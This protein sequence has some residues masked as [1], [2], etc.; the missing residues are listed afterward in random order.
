MSTRLRLLIAL[1]VVLALGL[2]LLAQLPAR[3]AVSWFRDT[4]PE[5]RAQGLSGTV[6]TGRAQRVDWRGY[7]LGALAWQIRPWSVLRGRLLAELTLQGPELTA[8][9]VLTSS[10]DGT[11][12]GAQKM[13]VSAPAAWLQQV[14]ATPFLQLSGTLDGQFDS[15]LFVDGWL[16]ALEGRSTWNDAQLRGRIRAPLGGLVVEWTTLE[17]RISGR[18]RDTGGPLQALG[19][20]VVENR[21]YHL[22]VTLAA[23]E[24]NIPLR[25][26]LEVF[27]R[28]NSDGAVMLR[29]EGPMI[30]LR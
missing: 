1:V 20:V 18:I 21:G 30:P 11:R 3:H 14:L 26:A 24:D 27:G 17:G 22:D 12:V 5:L 10:L 15:V 23:D 2:A 9:G 8:D 13:S 7:H 28:P 19:E 6:W 25:Q 16:H 29:L 4:V